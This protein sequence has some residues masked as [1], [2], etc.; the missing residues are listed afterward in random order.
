V[1]I[2]S[3][4]NV[5]LSTLHN[6]KALPSPEKSFWAVA[7]DANP[8]VKIENRIKANIDLNFIVFILRLF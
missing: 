7:M 1:P 4:V 5:P 3:V 8:K 6:A 2:K